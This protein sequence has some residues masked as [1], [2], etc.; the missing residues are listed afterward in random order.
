[1]PEGLTTAD[2]I[3]SYQ[4][5]ASHQVCVV[6]LDKICP[7]SV[8]FFNIVFQGLHSASVPGILA[9]DLSGDSSRALTGKNFCFAFQVYL[10]LTIPPL[11]LCYRWC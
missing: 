3:A 10:Q 7:V 2:D 11:S 6:K 5:V 1:M 8:I 4:Q 9:L